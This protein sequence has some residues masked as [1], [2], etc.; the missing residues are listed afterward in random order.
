MNPDSLDLNL[1][2]DA[3]LPPPPP[4]DRE[5]LQRWQAERIAEFYQSPHFE[6]W[7]ARTS[8]EMRRAKPFVW[9]D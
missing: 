4:V 1:P 5:A 6:E 9:I 8:E 3:P 7:Y 2:I